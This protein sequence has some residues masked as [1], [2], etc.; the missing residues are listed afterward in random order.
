VHERLFRHLL[1][2][3]DGSDASVAAA[4]LGFRVAHAFG[5]HVDVLYVIDL[6]LCEELQRFDQREVDEIRA[7]LRDHG[8]RY[9]DV[10]RDEAERLELSVDGEVRRGDPFEEIVAWAR[11]READLIVM[12]HVG[13][14]PRAKV[15]LGSVAERVLEFAPC[16]VMVVKHDP[17]ED[18]RRSA[19]R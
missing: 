11:E 7:E 1:I 19:K 5:A 4:R 9:V 6:L 2:P 14:R 8:Q 3:T 13:R 16:P 15:L 10:L 17:D 18:A 12:G